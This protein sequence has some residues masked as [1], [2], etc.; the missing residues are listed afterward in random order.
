MTCKPFTLGLGQKFA[1]LV[2]SILCVTLGVASHLM[3]HHQNVQYRNHLT[4]KAQLLGRFISLISPEAILSYD[5]QYLDDVMKEATNQKDMVYSVILDTHGQ[6]MTSFLDVKN[7]NIKNAIAAVGDSNFKEVIEYLKNADDIIHMSFPIRFNNEEIGEVLL[8]LSTQRL[9]L[10]VEQNFIRQLVGYVLIILILIL[11][12]HFVFR[13][14]VLK[15]INSLV[16]GFDRVANGNL[17]QK[18]TVLC[19]DELSCLSTSFNKMMSDL[20]LHITEKDQMMDQLQELNSTLEHRVRKRTADLAQS[21]AHIRAILENVGE[22]IITL[23]EAGYIQSVNPAAERILGIKNDSAKN[24]HSIFMLSDESASFLADSKEYID[25]NDNPIN[26]AI[27]PHPLVLTGKRMD[28]SEFPMEL[29]VTTMQKNSQVYRVCI[30]RDITRRKETE[31]RL[32]QAQNQLLDAAHKSGM[33]DMATGV[34]HNIGNILNSVN[35]AGEEISKIVKHSKIEGLSMANKMLVE[36]QNEL[37]DFLLHDKKGKRLPEYYI[38]VGT[39]LVDEHKR[40]EKEADSLNEKTK[41]MK[42]VIRTQ[43]L[44]ASAGFFSEALDIH[45]LINDAITVQKASLDKWGVRIEKRLGA[46]PSCMV[47]KSK[48]LQVLTNLVKNAKEAMAENDIYN[49]PKHLMI[50]TGQQNDGSVFVKILDNGCGIEQEH[51]TQIFGHG[52]TLKQN[53]H[54]FGL[55]TCANAVKEMGGTITAS[56]QGLQQGACFYLSLPP[57]QNTQVVQHDKNAA[58]ETADISE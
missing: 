28:G 3:A 21:E 46:I 27:A 54:G 4:E 58:L 5:L 57:A 47:Q 42:D 53:G 17:E 56:S 22:G 6:N 24:L 49:K 33:A 12:I 29:V 1:I 34:L 51:L 36:H 39:A 44:Y 23:D 32:E 19:K 26:R 37:S 48:L 7:T 35:L 13:Q 9:S 31:Q 50:E 41:M 8:G 15:P 45:T 14:K 40:I 10:E 52:F 11:C 30:L 20:K 18:V 2:V 16:E 43:Q 55:H 38:K 25:I